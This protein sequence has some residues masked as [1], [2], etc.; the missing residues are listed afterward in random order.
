M[1]I[2]TSNVLPIFV[3]S[4]PVSGIQGHKTKEFLKYEYKTQNCQHMGNTLVKCLANI[5]T[6]GSNTVKRLTCRDG[7]L[8][9]SSVIAHMHFSAPK[10]YTNMVQMVTI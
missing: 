9:V 1:V 3:Q 5:G 6:I 2:S 10:T 4:T 8:R 7:A